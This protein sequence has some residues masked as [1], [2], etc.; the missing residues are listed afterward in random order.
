MYLIIREFAGF[1]WALG[2]ALAFLA[3]KPLAFPLWTIANYSQWATLE[4]LIVLLAGLRF[5]SS[6]RQTWLWLAGFAIG[7]AGVTKQTSAGT[8]GVALAMTI[9]LDALLTSD[10]V[11][12]KRLTTI[13][14]RGATLA[15]AALIPIGFFALFYGAQGALAAVID[16]AVV[17]LLSYSGALG[18]PLPDLEVWSFD[19]AVLGPRSFVYFPSAVLSLAWQGGLNLY[20]LAIALTVEHSV[21]FAYYGPLLAAIGACF[22]LRGLASASPAPALR[23]LF[24]LLVS[25]LAYWNASFRADWT[26]L[27]TIMPEVILLCV[28]VL[29]HF[30][31]RAGFLRG[32]AVALAA[33]W[34]LAGSLVAAAAFAAYDAPL[35]TSR[36]LLY[37]TPDEA[38]DA[39]RVL[40]YVDAQAEASRIAFLPNHPIYYS[41]TG[42][43]ILSAFDLLIPAYFRPGDD[44]ALAADLA[45]V[46]QVVYD[47]NVLPTV[48]EAL[49]EFAPKSA[50]VLARR[51]DFT[52]A[53]SPTAYVL[54]A[55]SSERQRELDRSQVV[56]LFD[57]ESALPKKRKARFVDTTHWM[58]YRVL[59]AK[60]RAKQP[61]N[62]FSIPHEVGQAESLTFV[63]MFHPRL[64]TAGSQSDELRHLRFSVRIESPSGPVVT[65]FSEMREAGTPN[66]PVTIALDAHV[67]KQIVLSLCATRR[68]VDPGPAGVAGFAEA[69]IERRGTGE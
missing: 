26:H 1:A 7:L 8:L 60:I 27:M 21:K 14:T 9:A 49:A 29:H 24:V 34:I 56:D 19:M 36:G 47:P 20:S 58:M 50:R 53:L 22:A 35:E 30:A 3:V 31:A 15:A 65:P 39:R 51:F 45:Q 48:A 41:L 55:L 17:G 28:V 18:V 12:A 68:I 33:A 52:K 46:D 67:G 63:P 10:Q 42:R 13:A 16:R 5:L 57:R 4:G 69:R 43:R 44:D 40:D 11:V 32:F 23:I 61:G 2:G 38:R 25:G 37:V 62:C 64:W 54:E 6:R 59:A 66:R